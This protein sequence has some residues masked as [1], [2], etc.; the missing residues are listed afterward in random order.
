MQGGGAFEVSAECEHDALRTAEEIQQSGREVL[1]WL[2]ALAESEEPYPVNIHLIREIHRR[3]FESTFP[4]DAGRER[5]AVVLNRKGTA[6]DPEAIVPA[7]VNACAN[8][9]WRQKFAPATG[10]ELVAFNVA[11]A[12]TLVVSIYDV[13][14][15]VDGNTRTT[16][17]LRNYLLMLGGLRPLVDLRDQEAYEDAWWSAAPNDH[18]ALDASV[19]QEL[20]AQDR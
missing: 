20:A 12:N 9:D 1:P 16:W 3:W 2:E 8:W 6:A 14:P 18:D 19:I 17:D 4:A 5:H 11:E 7:V 10:P 13:H 15:F